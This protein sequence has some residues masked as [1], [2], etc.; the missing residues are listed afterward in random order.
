MKFAPRP[1]NDFARYI[2]T[3]YDECR[4]RFDRIEAIA[5][6]WTFGDLIPGMS[7]FDTRLICSDGMTA[8]DWS[9]MSAAV[10]RTHLELCRRYPH[11]ARN[12]E[13]LPGINLTW[14]ELT[15]ER[16]YY[17]EYRQWTFYHSE[18]PAAVSA[19]KKHFAARRWDAKDE[20]FH[21]KKFCLYFGRYD[22]AIDPAIN[23]GVHE[24]KYPLHSRIMHYFTP[25]VQ[26]A[27]CILQKRAVAGKLDAL[28]IAADMFDGLSCWDTIREILDADYRTPR[29]CEEPHLTEL[30]DQL[31][32]ALKV[33]AARL[34][35]AI[36]LVP[37][38]AALDVAAWKRALEGAPVEPAMIV[39]ENAR[40]SRLMKGR[41]WFYANAP[42]WF[43]ATWLIRNEL[44]R[45]GD[46]FFRVPFKT[47][48]EVRT[49]RTNDDPPAILAELRGG[50]LT[51]GEVEA[52]T[53]F[54]RLTTTPLE[55]GKEKQTALAIVAV[56]D[57]FF[58]AL[59]KISED[60]TNTR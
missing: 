39:F 5:G 4:L 16:T 11:W 41:L 2:R 47:Y 7:D 13:H 36:T 40:F 14:S 9:R 58:K 25:P 37:A 26:S 28:E 21:L 31:E 10:G 44:G 20:Y 56:F 3:Y 15:N 45:I 57:T 17:P 24:S 50:L 34:R 22:R 1:A 18:R 8:D 38:E 51:D 23:L 29:W 30:E 33:I 54:D 12:L 6:K 60:V 42:A 52:A 53:E 49:G 59:T 27:V 19:V 35:E 43:D 46:S 48:W 32:D 55:A